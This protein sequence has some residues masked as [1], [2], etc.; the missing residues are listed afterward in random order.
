MQV[1]QCPA[2]HP[3]RHKG[4]QY[5]LD[6]S[7]IK[8][9][10]DQYYLF[11]NSVSRHTDGIDW[12]GAGEKGSVCTA[13]SLGHED[14]VLSVTVSPD[15]AWIASG[16][17]DRTVQFWDPR[18]GQPRIKLYAQRNSGELGCELRVS[19]IIIFL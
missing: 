9:H 16:S 3:S 15:G 2:T 19:V 5:R 10:N 4:S 8:N 17:K 6:Q 1:I 13:T 7:T 14:F 18:T 12:Q 11:H